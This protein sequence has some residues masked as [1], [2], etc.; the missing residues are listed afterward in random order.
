MHQ[1]ERW[2]K[3]LDDVTN[4][5]QKNFASLTVDVLNKKPNADTWSIAQVLE[6]I[7]IINESYYP[8][9]ENVR[10]GNYKVGYFGSG[11]FMTHFW[12]KTIYKSIH[13]DNK[14]KSK[15]QAIW[16]PASS[17]ID[18]EI[19]NHFV[20]HQ[21]KFKMFLD[22]CSDLV[23][24]NTVIH[25]PAAKFITYTTGQAFEIITAHEQRHLIQA[26][27]VLQKIT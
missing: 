10:N 26:R 23:E 20:L 11:Q 14:K 18:S 21:N 19:V 15:T 2:K 7:I 4:E 9:I 27:E 1:I 13:P 12:F 8:V 22:G 25:S 17:N 3:I 24:N 5:V 16:Q 6:H